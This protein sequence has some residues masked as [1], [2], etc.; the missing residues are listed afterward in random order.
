MGDKPFTSIDNQLNIL[1]DRKLIIANRESA[2]IT[3]Q[4]YGYY[5]LINGYKDPFLKDKDNSDDFK[6]GITFE[7]IASLQDMDRNIRFAVAN[8]LEIFEE[9][10]RQAI[11]YVIA[12]DISDEHSIY[13][14]REKYNSGKKFSKHISHGRVITVWPIDETLYVLNK[15]VNSD[16]EPIHHYRENHGNVPPWIL[17]KEATFGNLIWIF[18]LLKKK[19]KSEVIAILLGIDVTLIDEILVKYHI[20]R[21]FKELLLLMLNYRNTASHGGRV[22]NHYS[23]KYSLSYNEYFHKKMNVSQGDYRLKKGRSRIGVLCKVLELFDDANASR[24]L[25]VSVEFY[26][27]KYLKLYS[28]DEAFLLEE[29]EIGPNWRDYKF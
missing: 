13:L 19:Q 26:L 3:L 9:N 12:S 25:I 10:F 6:D 23:K 4:R 2:Y 22:Y 21:G 17:L 8:S 11:A 27:E 20:K 7:R 16:K 28:D 24:N 15:L 1:D 14:K 29:M 5:E 18:N